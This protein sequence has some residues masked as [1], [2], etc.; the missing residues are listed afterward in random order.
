MKSKLGAV[1]ASRL[2]AQAQRRAVLF[3]ALSSCRGAGP[4]RKSNKSLRQKENQTIR[5][6]NRA[7]S[8]E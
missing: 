6:G 3:S 5:Q 8:A 4:H 1:T 2:S 7:A